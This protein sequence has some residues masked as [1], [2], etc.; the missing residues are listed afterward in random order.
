MSH[1]F[2]KLWRILSPLAP[3]LVLALFVYVM[4]AWLFAPRPDWT[5]LARVTRSVHGQRPHNPYLGKRG[6]LE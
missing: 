2:G 1:L 6:A 5:I 3:G 4:T